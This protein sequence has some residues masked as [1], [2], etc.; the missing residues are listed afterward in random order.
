MR[1]MNRALRPT[2]HLPRIPAREGWDT[3]TIIL[4]FGFQGEV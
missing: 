3:A 2:D 4:R 1:Q